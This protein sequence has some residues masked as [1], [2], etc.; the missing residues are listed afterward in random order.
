MRKSKILS[1]IHSGK[2]ARLTMLG[3]LVPPFIAHTAH[4]RFDGIWLDLEHRPM[5]Q[6]E[7]ELLISYC[8]LY[9]I[10]C[11]IR[12]ASKEK[13]ALYRYLEDGATGLVI[14]HVNSVDEV[15]DL[16]QSIKFPPIGDRGFAGLGLDTNFGTDKAAHSRAEILEFQR[17]ET[18]VIIQIETPSALAALDEI[19]SVPGVDGLYIGPT[20]MSIRMEHLPDSEQITMDQ[21]ISRVAF[22]A[23]QHDL[24]WGVFCGS[25][26]DIMSQAKQGANLLM[27]GMDFRI[28]A[29]GLTQAASVL[30]EA[31]D[32]S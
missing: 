22:V 19:A 10:D 8:H 14:Q 31:T 15:R 13:T 12:P 24:A 30:D 1:K 23:K 7:V 11:M 18:F 21:V 17:N 32:E 28:I 2:S 29:D 27:W 20:D 26:D 9:D 25:P 4:N 3:N 5:E 6:R 16:V